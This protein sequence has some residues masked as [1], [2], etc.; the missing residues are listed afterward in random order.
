M[1][2]TAA[3]E[4]ESGSDIWR[5]AVKMDGEIKRRKLVSRRQAIETCKLRKKEKI[6]KQHERKYPTLK[7]VMY[8]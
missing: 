4:A 3:L 1:V 7:C 2:I 8:R 6:K 5:A